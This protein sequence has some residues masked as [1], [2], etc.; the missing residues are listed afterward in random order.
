VA[1][2]AA[3]QAKL[4]VDR[5]SIEIRKEVSDSIE[6]SKALEAISFV[7]SSAL[8]QRITQLEI[9][10]NNLTNSVNDSLDEI[11]NE[12]N[13]LEA[14]LN[15]LTY[16]WVSL[17]PTIDVDVDG[18][19]KTTG[20]YLMSSS[21]NRSRAKA[22]FRYTDQQPAGE[23]I[24]FKGCSESISVPGVTVLKTLDD[25]HF[26]DLDCYQCNK[27][28]RTLPVGG[29]RDVYETTILFFQRTNQLY[30]G[31]LIRYVA[32]ASTAG[33]VSIAYDVEFAD[34]L[35]V[36][37]NG[38]SSVWKMEIFPTSLSVKR[39]FPVKYDGRYYVGFCYSV[40]AEFY[41]E[42]TTENTLQIDA[43]GE[44]SG[45]LS[46]LQPIGRNHYYLPVVKK[47]TTGADIIPIGIEKTSVFVETSGPS[48]DLSK[49][50][51]LNL[52]YTGGS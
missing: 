11:T 19:K 37:S 23:D 3:N 1:A 25:S 45:T 18:I 46:G 22:H 47:F 21:T 9:K 15:G 42:N 14:P 16:S 20:S 26:M 12:V 2:L 48:H 5:E 10:V 36:T 27:A 44:W 6:L 43:I 34:G 35:T 30:D 41:S 39:V 28:N 32:P 24:A 4:A 7:N 52:V 50:N 33:A 51:G 40:S 31:S 8:M 29:T 17:F 38:S 13:E 49:L